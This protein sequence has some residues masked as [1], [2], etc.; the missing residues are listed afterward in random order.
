MSRRF[1]CPWGL[2]FFG[3]Q[4][5]DKAAIILEPAFLLMYYGG[6]SYTEI[7]NLP[8]SYKRWFVERISKELNRGKETESKALHQNTPDVRALQGKVRDQV[9]ARLRRFT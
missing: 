3:L 2:A 1:Q 6:F 5:Q 9:P 7:Y 4:S 8:V